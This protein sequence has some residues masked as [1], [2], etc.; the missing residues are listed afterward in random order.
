MMGSQGLV[1]S[2]IKFGI[3]T[4]LATCLIYPTI[5]FVPLPLPLTATLIAAFGPLLAIASIGLSY[6]L[7][8]HQD[9]LSAQLAPI[10]NA[11]GGALF[12][13]MLLVQVAVDLRAEPE[14]VSRQVEAIWLGL[15][16]A[17]DAYVGL[18]TLLFALAMR[19]HPRFG[20]IFAI[21]GAV[22]AVVFL[23]LNLYTFPVPPANAGLIDL[24]PEVGLWYLAV[25]FQMW[26]SLPW[27][28]QRA[29]AT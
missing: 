16:V 8:L 11:L 10:L 19:K 12:S 1:L 21:S 3:G 15:D 27:A 9:S 13:V 20:S 7:R 28:A 29:S 5:V 2:W 26:R 4:G 6:A 22:L 24:G 25:T 17:W 14:R 23:A 18:G